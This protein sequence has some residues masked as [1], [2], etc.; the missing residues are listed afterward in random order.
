MPI[1]FRIDHE[2][3]IVIARGYG[4]LTDDDLFSYQREAWS[5][6]DVIGYNELVDLTLVSEIESPSVQR[7]RALAS[8]AAH[9]DPASV[10]SRFAIVAPGDLAYG[11]GRMFQSYR[12]LESSSTKDVRVFR[13]LSEALAFLEISQSVPLPPIPPST[14]TEEQ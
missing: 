7:L 11:L 5:G 6:K 2:R 14:A 9:M 1:T 4:R 12:E 8:I 3:R 13:M 10:P